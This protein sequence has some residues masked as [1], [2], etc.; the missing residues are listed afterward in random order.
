MDFLKRLELLMNAR[1]IN[2]KVLAEQAKIPVSTV[3]SWWAKGYEGITLPTII[4][5]CD[6]FHCSMDWLCCGEECE[7]SAPALSPDELQ[8]IS[9]YRAADVAIQISVKKLL[10]IPEAK[11][12]GSAQS[13]M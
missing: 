12:S 2:K 9:A 3:Y 13:A 10:D 7:A 8:L 11:E 5:L 6:Y 1:E 4:K